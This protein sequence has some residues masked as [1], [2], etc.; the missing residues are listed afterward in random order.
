MWRNSTPCSTPLRMKLSYQKRLEVS[1]QFLASGFVFG[2]GRFG[3]AQKILSWR[4]PI[5]PAQPAFSQELEARSQKLK[6]ANGE[7]GQFSG[8]ERADLLSAPQAVGGV[9]GGG[10]NR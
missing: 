3:G 8:L 10:R 2:A 5:Q 7:I 9:D 6:C 1:S 4:A